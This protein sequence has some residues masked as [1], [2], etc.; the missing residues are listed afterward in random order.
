MMDGYVSRTLPLVRKW[1][2]LGLVL[3]AVVLSGCS[4][5]KKQLQ[6][7]VMQLDSQVADLQQQVAQKETDIAECE[8]ITNELKENLKKV[9]ADRDVCV[10]KLN[11]VVIVKIPETIL[12]A[13]G[14]DM[15]LDT[16]VPTLKVIA[17]AIDNHPGWDAF[18][19]GY[20][21]SKKILEEYQEKWPSNWELG[22]FRAA[23]VV[24]YLTN[25]L[26]LDA[27]RF[28]VVSYGPFRPFESNDTPEGR[29][30]NRV[31]QIVMHKPER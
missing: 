1:T 23:A 5:G 18:V 11:E 29:A 4:S 17:Q 27:R 13:S 20:T 14:T 2:L 10:Q 26:N 24:R 21:D 15:I 25:D 9:E 28:A 30:A 19:E 8:Q 31:V 7:Q 16:M 6:E 12:F 3:A 22:A